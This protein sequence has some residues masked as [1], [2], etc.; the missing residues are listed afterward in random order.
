[1][2]VLLGICALTCAAAALHGL[3]E[4][5]IAEP[6][7]SRVVDRTLRCSIAER[8]GVRRVEVS[9]QTGTRLFGDATKWKLLAH[10]SVGDP[11]D[12]IAGVSAGNPLAPLEPGF[13]APPERLSFIAGAKCRAVA[14]RI[15]LS[16]RGIERL[17]ASPPKGK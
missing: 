9:A 3:E 14:L 11:A 6:T 10:A 17:S 4:T 13:P 5:A 12:G 15:P 1:M 16:R 7:A 8:A 2:K